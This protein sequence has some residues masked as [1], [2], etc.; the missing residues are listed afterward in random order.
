MVL[1]LSSGL[2]GKVKQELLAGGYH[3]DTPVAVVYKATW[4]EEK[5]LH[6]TVEKL[7]EA[8]E[9]AGICKT[10]LIV[11]GNVLGNEYQK[12]K[13]YDASFTTGYRKKA[14]DFNTD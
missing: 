13:L 8:M 10:A 1:F 4:P 12:S 11:I 7:P 2:A 3:T 9:G 6:T 5:I 14:N